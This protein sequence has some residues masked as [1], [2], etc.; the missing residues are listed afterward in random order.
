MKISY[1]K[2]KCP[3]RQL[4]DLRK[5]SSTYERILKW[6]SLSLKG[7]LL[8]PTMRPIVMAKWMT[9]KSDW[10]WE[11]V[12]R[13]EEL[14]YLQKWVTV[15]STLTL[16]NYLPNNL[17]E[18]LRLTTVSTGSLSSSLLRKKARARATLASQSVFLTQLSCTPSRCRRRMD[19]RRTSAWL[20]HN[21]WEIKFR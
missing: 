10:R 1:Q 4:K 11:S 21:G 9:N 19:C 15:L 5:S 20:L 8:T 2:N 3:R 7:R 14:P 6:G 12:E 17:N 16:G 13:L 18:F